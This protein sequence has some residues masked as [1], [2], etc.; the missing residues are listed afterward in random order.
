MKDVSLQKI[1]KESKARSVITAQSRAYIDDWTKNWFDDN[2]GKYGL[3]EFDKMTNN[4]G[5]AW[6]IHL[7]DVDIP[8]GFLTKMSTRSGFPNIT[9]GSV[10]QPFTYEVM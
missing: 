5:K 2:M 3:K 7:K 8:K 4:I 6:K 10:F 1:T 9:S